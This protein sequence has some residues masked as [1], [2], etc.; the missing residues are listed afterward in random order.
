MRF[1]LFF[2]FDLLSGKDE[3]A[4]LA[5]VERQAILADQLG[6]DRI[7]FAEHHFQEYGRMPSP[8]MFLSRISGMTSNIRLGTAIVEAPYYHPI[9]LAEDGALLDILSGGRLD[10][11]LGS[12]AGNKVAEFEHFSMPKSE[13]GARLREIVQILWQLYGDSAISH[14]GEFYTFHGFTISPTPI[15]ERQSLL[16]LAAS[17]GSIDIAGEL[18]LPIMMPRVTDDARLATLRSEYRTRLPA[19][20]DGHIAALRFTFV[21][22]TR[23]EARRQTIDT[24]R[25]YAKYDAGIDWNGRSDTQEYADICER[26]RFVAGTAD[27]VSRQLERWERDHE[28][29][30]VMCQMFAAGMKVDDAMQSM[31]LFA[32]HVAPRF[33][34]VTTGI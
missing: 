30:E 22:P 6:Y 2:N 15:Q 21:A 20:V 10:L 8:L 3:R 7:W 1:S 27:D 5:E 4:L 33:R 18:G 34:Q 17:M 26:I 28:I 31:S 12:G 29:D 9:R 14:D 25:R 13:K 19:G 24:F 11:G 32:E 23:E 16:W